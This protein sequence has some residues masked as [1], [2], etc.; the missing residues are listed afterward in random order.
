MKDSI[1]S[2]LR[3]MA[4]DTYGSSNFL[5]AITAPDLYC[6]HKTLNLWVE[7]THLLQYAIILDESSSYHCSY[8]EPIPTVA[9]PC[10]RT[11]FLH[12]EQGAQKPLVHLTVRSEITFLK[13]N[14]TKHENICCAQQKAGGFVVFC[15]CFFKYF[16]TGN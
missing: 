11:H 5:I 12:T 14:R 6:I 13:G 2:V 8:L 7:S 1:P 4:K 16:K 10:H 9:S 15:F 3:I